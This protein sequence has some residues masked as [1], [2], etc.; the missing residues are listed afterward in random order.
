[1]ESQGRAQKEANDRGPRQDG[2][3]GPC[4]A[5]EHAADGL[6]GMFPV[7]QWEEDRREHR[8]YAE[9]AREEEQEGEGLGSDGRRKDVEKNSR[10]SWGNL[11]RRKMTHDGNKTPNRGLALAIARYGVSRQYPFK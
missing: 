9:E 7:T 8:D 4:T 11:A 3:G 6:E 2:R 5:G 1:M 10:R